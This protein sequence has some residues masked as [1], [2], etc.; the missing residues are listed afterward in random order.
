LTGLGISA[1]AVPQDKTQA[2]PK[3]SRH[4]KMIK[5]ENGKK[6][7]LDTVLTGDDIFVW[8]GDTINPVKHV[9]KFSH[10]GFD[11]MHHIDVEGDSAHKKI[12]IHKRL[13][14]GNEADHFV[15]L[16]EPR[17]KHF[18]PMPPMPPVPHLK[19][20]KDKHSGRSINLND[21]NIISFKK[22]DLSGDREKIEIIRKKTEALNDMNFDFEIDHAMM[23][24]EPPHIMDEFNNEESG[25]KHMEEEIE[26]EVKEGVENQKKI[27]SEE[28]K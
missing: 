6:M 20:M 26:V 9:K 5:M 28:N 21:P 7:E 19:M 8:N 14:D 12:I 13:H 23:A 4:I 25:Q 15:Y 27:E 24:P 16:N 17:M 11:K 22:K 2:Q 18:P 3:K 1:W 10:A